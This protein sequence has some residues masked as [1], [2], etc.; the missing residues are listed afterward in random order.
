MKLDTMPGEDGPEGE[1][2]V[3][4]VEAEAEAV[5]TST[6]LLPLPPATLLGSG[7]T[8]PWC[9]LDM[10]AAAAAALAVLRT[11]RTRVPIRPFHEPWVIWTPILGLAPAAAPPAPLP[12]LGPPSLT[13]RRSAA[14]FLDAL[15]RDWLAKG[16]RAKGV[17]AKGVRA[18][19]VRA[20]EG[21]TKGV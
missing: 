7:A 1:P 19:G 3:V 17:R 6:V 13:T 20:K 5:D 9:T 12:P 14:S 10:L 11:S 18:K 15:L 4:L 16:V 21:M 2:G 8:T